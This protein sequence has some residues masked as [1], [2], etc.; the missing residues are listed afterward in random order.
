MHYGI[1]TTTTCWMKPR[2]YEGTCAMRSYQCAHVTFIFSACHAAPN[3]EKPYAAIN[4]FTSSKESP[5]SPE[6]RFQLIAAQ[7]TRHAQVCPTASLTSS[8]KPPRESIDADTLLCSLAKCDPKAGTSWTLCWLE[9]SNANCHS[10]LFP[11]NMSWSETNLSSTV[12]K[13]STTNVQHIVPPSLNGAMTRASSRI[14]CLSAPTHLCAALPLDCI[15]I[16]GFE[17]PWC[18]MLW[19]NYVW[20]LISDVCVDWAAN[21]LFSEFPTGSHFRKHAERWNHL[22]CTNLQP[23]NAF[24]MVF[25]CFLRYIIRSLVQSKAHEPELLYPT[26]INLGRKAGSGFAPN[27][28]SLFALLVQCSFEPLTLPCSPREK[29]RELPNAKIQPHCKR[30]VRHAICRVIA[31]IFMTSVAGTPPLHSIV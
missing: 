14:L 27:V 18:C 21:L 19:L 10:L 26:L 3:H 24:L 30:V 31:R 12:V 22:C 2:P 11:I 17:L 5:C 1:W 8:M 25:W 16:A 9:P 29:V 28:A 4:F 7:L 20:C 15:K 6:T 23:R 13:D